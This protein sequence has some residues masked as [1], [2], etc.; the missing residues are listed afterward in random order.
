[1]QGG[2]YAICPSPVNAPSVGGLGRNRIYDGAYVVGPSAANPPPVIRA[3]EEHSL[4]PG[5]PLVEIKVRNVPASVVLMMLIG[6]RRDTWLG[7]RNRRPGGYV[8]GGG[9]WMLHG[10]QFLLGWMGYDAFLPVW[11]GGGR[12][13]RL[14]SG[15]PPRLVQV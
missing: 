2:V 11:T 12:P 1:M 14:V 9:R 15:P 6:Y 13:G 3:P 8:F 5:A 10:V 7:P 4:A